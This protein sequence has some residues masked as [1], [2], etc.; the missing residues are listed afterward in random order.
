LFYII[1]TSVHLLHHNTENCQGV[2]HYI[3][4]RVVTLLNAVATVQ[5]HEDSCH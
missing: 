5:Q 3:V 2:S 4:W 1:Y